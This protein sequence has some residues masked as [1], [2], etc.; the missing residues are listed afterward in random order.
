MIAQVERRTPLP[1]NM[2]QPLNLSAFGHHY[3]FDIDLRKAELFDH[4]LVDR[5]CCSNR[6]RAN[7]KVFKS[8]HVKFSNNQHVQWC[9]E[10]SGNLMSYGNTTPRQSENDNIGTP[11]V[12]RKLLA[13][14]APRLLTTLKSIGHFGFAS[15]EFT[16]P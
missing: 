10:K 14:K 1:V 3:I 12:A 11:R 13:K 6:N 16:A 9:L 5:C 4:I 8:G 2:I 7:R 15:H